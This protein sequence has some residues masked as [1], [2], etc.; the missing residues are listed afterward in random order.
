[1]YRA[2][3]LAFGLGAH[4][5]QPVAAERRGR[6]LGAR[7]AI[8][9][10]DASTD[11]ADTLDWSEVYSQLDLALRYLTVARDSTRG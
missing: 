5:H 10:D 7:Q 4:R 8:P 6:R 3:N 2:A 1:M 9:P 11:E